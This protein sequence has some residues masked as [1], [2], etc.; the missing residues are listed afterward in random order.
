MKLVDKPVYQSDRGE[1]FTSKADA[2]NDDVSFYASKIVNLFQKDIDNVVYKD[3][4]LHELCNRDNL[5]I[6]KG[7][8]DSMYTLEMLVKKLVNQEMLEEV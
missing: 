3:E 1:I 5:N 4:L 6:I 2:L 7:L 8:F